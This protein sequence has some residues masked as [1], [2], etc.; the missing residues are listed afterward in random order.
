[1]GEEL[2]PTAHTKI[3]TIAHNGVDKELVNEVVSLKADHVQSLSAV[4]CKSL[5]QHFVKDYNPYKC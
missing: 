2:V 4:E 3:Y 1:E 5:I